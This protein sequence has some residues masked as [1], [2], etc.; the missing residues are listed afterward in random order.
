MINLSRQEVIEKLS[1]SEEF[2][3]EEI[4]QFREIL[5]NTKK[6]SNWESSS[7]NSSGCYEEDTWV[8]SSYC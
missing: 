3:E 7:W 8:N 1:S 4:K 6:E 5:A 2:S